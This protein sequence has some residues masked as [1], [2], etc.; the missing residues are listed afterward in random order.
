[1]A[2]PGASATGVS[3]ALAAY[4]GARYIEAQLRSIL[5]QLEPHD[6]VVV[7]DD[8]S[9]DATVATIAALN[10]PRVRLLANPRNLGVVAS[11]ERALAATRGDPIFLSDQD[12]L[13]LP[14]KRTACCAAFAADPAVT[15][16]H[17]DAEII[18]GAGRVVAPSYMR[19]R[20][21]FDGGL[22]TT[23]VKNRYLGCAMAIRRSLLEAALPFPTGVPMH[24]LWLGTVNAVIGRTV[25]LDRP[26][27]QYRRHG[28]NVSLARHGTLPDMLHRRFALLRALALRAPLLWRRRRRRGGV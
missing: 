8:A 18:D 1:M 21:G 12:D 20:G 27:L 9:T 19:L 4:N 5:E 26:L 15:L 11:F 25:Y 10:D 22:A 23:V 7:V 14:G 3:V 6:E 17:S 13:W 28:G 24:D 16:V 2:K